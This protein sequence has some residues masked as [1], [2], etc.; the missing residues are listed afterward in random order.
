LDDLIKQTSNKKKEQGNHHST[1]EARRKRTC[2][3]NL[4]EAPLIAGSFSM[5]NKTHKNT[6]KEKIITVGCACDFSEFLSMVDVL[7]RLA[8]TEQHQ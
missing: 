8:H 1:K 7:F 3:I 2:F 5:N 4:H 6:H